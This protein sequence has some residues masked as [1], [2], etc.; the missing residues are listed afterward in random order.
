MVEPTK[1]HDPERARD[2]R[3]PPRDV[4]EAVGTPGVPAPPG[5][6]SEADTALDARVRLK[7]TMGQALSEEERLYLARLPG[8]A[9]IP[10][11]DPAKDEPR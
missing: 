7:L 6:M 1:R 8:D 5:P 10:P 3:A 2:A 9:R 4:T 11:E